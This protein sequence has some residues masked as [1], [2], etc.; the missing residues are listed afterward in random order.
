MNISEL[1]ISGLLVI[2]PA[3][4]NDERGYFFESF[5]KKKFMESG[6][7]CDFVQDNESMSSK[8]VLR[9][10]HLQSPP[11]EQGKLVRVIQGSVLDIA[12]DIRRHSPTFGKYHAITL[13]AANK[14]QFWI[15]PGF[16]HGFL[17]LEDHT[18]FTYKCTNY[19]NRES[20][21][22]I[23]WDDPDIN[24]DWGIGSPLVSEKD[25]H[26]PLFRDFVSPF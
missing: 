1:P 12:V 19:Y 10:L 9:G 20:E 14:L 24:I 3:I 18:I 16:A 26:A 23:R 22:S 15:P 21:R 13:S 2:Q 6:I 5:Q 8:G 25:N 4:F 17:A 7:N 11:Y